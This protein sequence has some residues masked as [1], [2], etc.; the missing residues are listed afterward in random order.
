M[1]KLLMILVVILHQD[2]FSQGEFI[3]RGQY[4]YGGGFQ[5]AVSPRAYDYG[6]SGALSG[7]GTLDLNI[8]LF[9]VAARVHSNDLNPHSGAVSFASDLHLIKPGQ[10]FPVGISAKGEYEVERYTSPSAVLPLDMHLYSFGGF[11]YTPI[12]LFADTYLQ[13]TAGYSVTKQMKGDPILLDGPIRRAKLALPI[14]FKSIESQT[15]I[16]PSIT[17]SQNGPPIYSLTFLFISVFLN[18]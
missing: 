17:A 11:I 18:K 13:P 4:A 6:V 7:D 14:V 10:S 15:I 3:E 16:Y 8:S 5:L 12:Q 2:L 9:L 1:K